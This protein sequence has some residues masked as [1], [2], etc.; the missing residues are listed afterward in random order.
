VKISSLTC[1]RF[2]RR[3]HNPIITSAGN[4]T[5]RTGLIIRIETDTGIVGFG[6]AGDDPFPGNVIQLGQS[7]PEDILRAG[8]PDHLS[9]RPVPENL[10]EITAILDDIIP[11]SKPM[12][13]FGLETALCDLSARVQGKPMYDWF[14]GCRRD[15]IPVNYLVIRPVNRW[16]DVFNEL[17]QGKYPALKFKVGSESIA[18]ETECVRLARERLGADIAIRLDA[19]RGWTYEM[20]VT[21]LNSLRD[22]GIDYVEEPLNTSHLDDYDRL[23]NE[24]GVRVALDETLLIRDDFD[25]CARVADVFILKPAVLGGFGKARLIARAAEASHCRVVLTSTYETEIGMAAILHWAASLAVDL[26]PCGL[27]TIRLFAAGQES[28]RQV[29]NGAIKVPTG[30]GLGIDDTF[31]NKL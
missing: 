28:L 2:R 10:D 25:P 29:E 13:R 6:E 30:I 20:A 17:Q 23:R 5:H 31:W 22:I 24:T 7:M 8:L 1:K 18:R 9:N 16:Q 26:P 19:N 15:R 4:L 12:L 27:D 21:L 14:G 11:D 3:F